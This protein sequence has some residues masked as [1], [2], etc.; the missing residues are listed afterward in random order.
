MS[1]NG[2]ARRTID[3]LRTLDFQLDEDASSRGVRVY[4]HT[5]APDRRIKVFSGIS[6][7][8]AIKAR[9]L[10]SELAGMSSAGEHVPASIRENARIKRAEAKSKRQAEAARHA[11]E[12]APFQQAADERAKRAALARQIE[13]DEQH[14]REVEQLMMPGR[15]H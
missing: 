4:W 15:S 10:A 13:A 3:V 6:E 7:I 11:A 14:R 2:N 12:L 5:N 9:N 8:A 1:M